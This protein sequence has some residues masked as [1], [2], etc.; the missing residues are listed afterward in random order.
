MGEH[1]NAK[2]LARHIL[3]C[4]EQ[5][6]LDNWALKVILMYCPDAYT[7]RTWRRDLERFCEDREIIQKVHVKFSSLYARIDALADEKEV[8]E[9]LSRLPTKGK[10]N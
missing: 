7:K 1:I 9:I 5:L 6:Y 2:K 3:R 8:L 10:P 4:Y